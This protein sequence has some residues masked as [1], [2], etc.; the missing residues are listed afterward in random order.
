MAGVF[1]AANDV[2]DFI[3][4]IGQH[5]DVPLDKRDHGAHR[6]LGFGSA[7]FG[8]HL[9]AHPCEYVRRLTHRAFHDPPVQPL[10][11]VVRLPVP[12]HRLHEFRNYA[13]G[14]AHAGKRTAPATSRDSRVIALLVVAVAIVHVVVEL[15]MLHE[16]VNPRIR[17]FFGFALHEH[18]YAA[19]TREGAIHCRLRTGIYDGQGGRDMRQHRRLRHENDGQ[20][21]GGAK[22]GLYRRGITWG[23]AAA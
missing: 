1:H 20:G 21:N 2:H 11:D 4:H 6:R 9:L 8:V 10:H 19:V 18:E 5:R 22:R 16:A 23:A 7:R 14:G 17:G 12:P 3:G 13:D 15:A